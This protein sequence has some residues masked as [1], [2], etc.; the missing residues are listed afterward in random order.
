MKFEQLKMDEDKTIS[1]YFLRIEELVNT[2]KGLGETIYE[3]F[4]VQKILRSLPDRFN[5]KVYA[6]EEITDLKT[7]TLDQIVGTLTA[8]EMRI[9]KGK[10]TTREASFKENKNTNPDIVEIEENFVRIL[11]KGSGKYKGKLPLKCF[12]CGKIGQ[13]SSKCPHNRKDQTYNDEDKHKHQKVYKEN[14]FKKK[15]LCVNN[16]DDPSDDENNDSPIESKINDFMLMTLEDLNID[17][18]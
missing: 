5:S 7:L 13:F 2:M 11:V 6:I 17:Q 16:D 8:Y 14:N 9:T 4:L 18:N 3:S 1:K 10:S 15:I 12:K